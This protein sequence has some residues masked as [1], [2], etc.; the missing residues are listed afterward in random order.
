ELTKQEFK[1]YCLLWDNANFKINFENCSQEL[2]EQNN[3]NSE[4]FYVV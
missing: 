2:S 3:T 1:E 4:V